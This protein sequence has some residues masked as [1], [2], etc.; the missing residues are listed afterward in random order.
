MVIFLHYA[1]EILFEILDMT[2]NMQ[3]V[4]KTHNIV[5]TSQA[6][7]SWLSLCHIAFLYVIHWSLN[8]SIPGK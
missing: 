8:F 5:V 4:G 1:G 2:A 7:W 6:C 3:V